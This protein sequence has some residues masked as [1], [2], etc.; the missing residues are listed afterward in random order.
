[1]PMESRGLGNAYRP[2]HGQAGGVW[3]PKPNSKL[4]PLEIPTITDRVVQT[5]VLIVLEAILQ[6]GSAPV[7]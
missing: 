3:L 5:V 2:G 4:Y 1:M 7:P 6:G